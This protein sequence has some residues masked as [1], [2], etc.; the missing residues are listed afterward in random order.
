M[1]FPK[2]LLADAGGRSF[3]ARILATLAAAGLTDLV[4]VTGRDHDAVCEALSAGAVP[5]PPTV[6]RNPDPSRGQLSSLWVGMDAVRAPAAPGLLVTLVDV[7]LVEVSTVR[8]LLDVWER[9]RAPV[10]RPA[11][12][13][14]H[15]HP[16][17]FDRVLFEE[18][19]RAPIDAGAKA[20]LQAHAAQVVDVPVEDEGCL[21]DIDTPE[22]Y[23]RM[24][25]S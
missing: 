13:D 25:M 4:V 24:G 18:L 5:V 7:P 8:T 14:R 15:G 11:R 22:Q 23:G 6:V 3:V 2:A 12:G 20:V 10:V 21:V 1:G 9:T 19:R 17:I 16:V